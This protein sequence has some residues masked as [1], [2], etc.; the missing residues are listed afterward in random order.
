[1]LLMD[2]ENVQS[3]VELVESKKD[4]ATT[5]R[6]LKLNFAGHEVKLVFE[7]NR[8]V[9]TF[10]VNDTNIMNSS[11][12]KY[13]GVVEFNIIPRLL[14]LKDDNV[15][16]VLDLGLFRRFQ[17]EKLLLAL[18]K[19]LDDFKHGNMSNQPMLN[20]ISKCSLGSSEKMLSNICGIQAGAYWNEHIQDL[21]HKPEKFHKIRDLIIA[22]KLPELLETVDATVSSFAQNTHYIAPL[23]ATAERYYRTQGLAND[24]V[25][26]EGKNLSLFIRGL[27]EG[28]KKSFQNWTL[29]HFGFFIKPTLG[30]GHISLNVIEG[31]EGKET[32][33]A[34]TGFGLSQILPVVAQLWVLTQRSQARKITTSR[35]FLHSP[36]MHFTLAIE[37]P[38]LHLHPMLQSKVAE[39]L[40]DA[41]IV[42]RKSSIELRLIVETH[43]EVIVN[44]I[45]E[46]IYRKKFDKD[47]V[48]IILFEKDSENTT[49]LRD[50]KY[51]SEGILEDWPI[52]FLSPGIN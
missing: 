28:E 7:E 8:A 29:E 47:D 42:A 12:A 41:I 21:K 46:S 40:M 13:T 4:G 33:L 37:Q 5:V 31:L 2:D 44:T 34:D 38:E 30:G 36:T 50:T 14:P 23:R 6:A 22:L 17:N 32:N 20:I 49:T 3:S 1:M 45:G 24:T 11:E 18:I 27:S 25:D 48:K 43:S 39:L 35:Q 16:D 19:E 10:S 51:D 26:P 52:G 15:A 9:Q